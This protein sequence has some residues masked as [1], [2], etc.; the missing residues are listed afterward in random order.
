MLSQGQ[1]EQNDKNIWTTSY[2]GFWGHCEIISRSG[3][4][5]TETKQSANATKIIYG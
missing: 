5:Q 4:G 1:T 2:I 3:Q